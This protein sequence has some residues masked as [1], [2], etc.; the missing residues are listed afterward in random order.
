[1]LAGAHPVFQYVFMAWCLIKN[2]R[3][4]GVVLI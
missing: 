4:H 2:L 3:F 1:M